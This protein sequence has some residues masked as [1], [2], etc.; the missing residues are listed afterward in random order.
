MI[1][2]A[3]SDRSAPNPIGRIGT[4]GTNLFAVGLAPVTYVK[5][6]IAT[7]IDPDRNACL[8]K[9]GAGLLPPPSRYQDIA[10]DVC[11]FSASLRPADS[12][13]SCLNREEISAGQSVNGLLVA[14]A[15]DGIAF[16]TATAW[17]QPDGTGNTYAEVAS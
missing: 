14:T 1:R 6:S 13:T 17:V 8:N 5:S 10:E 12:S 2:N 15:G 4:A 3:Q 16:D 7:R 9:G 11:I